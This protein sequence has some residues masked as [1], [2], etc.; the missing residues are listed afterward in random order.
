MKHALVGVA[1]WLASSRALSLDAVPRARVAQLA[2]SP[3]SCAARFVGNVKPQLSKKRFASLAATASPEEAAPEEKSRQ[4]SPRVLVGASAFLAAIMSLEAGGLAMAGVPTTIV[5]AG[6]GLVASTLSAAAAKSSVALSPPVVIQALLG[7][8]LPHLAFFAI[9]SAGLAVANC[10]MFT[11]PLWTGMFATLVGAPWR[12]RD[13]VVSVLS[14]LGVVLVARPPALFGGAA[15]LFSIGG[16]AAA[17]AFGA[18]G[19][20]LN[21]VLGSPDLKDSSPA[22]LTA[23]QMLVS[24][25]IAVPTLAQ[26][27]LPP[28]IFTL[29]TAARLGLVGVLMATQSALRTTG[30]QLA[31]DVTVA[32]I[33][34]TEIAWCFLLDIL[35][36]GAR[37]RLSQ[38]GGAAL[39]VGSATIN[40]LLVRRELLLQKDDA[41]R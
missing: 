31:P 8:T 29:F 15:E 13:T 10:L 34:Y 37:P 2:R 19:G 28:G 26:S 38:Y 35:V 27:T 32:T 1:V 30:L 36:L 3:L 7:G 14:L 16:C 20:A 24:A 40:S 12:F 41:E 5:A 17:L 33:L 22:M 4:Q 11:M 9:S 23:Y 18:V 21:I 25:V 6:C 39:I